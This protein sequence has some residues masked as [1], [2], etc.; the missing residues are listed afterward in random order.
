[1]GLICLQGGNE[2]APECRDMDA[3]LL[4]RAGGGTVVLVPLAGAPGRE[5]DTAGANGA[6]HFAALGAD[7]V[8]VAPD[9]RRDLAGALAAVND[10]RLLVLPGGSPRRLRDAIAGTPL[11]DAVHAAASD[12][13]R[14]VM[15]SS[16]GAMVLCRVTVLPRWRGTPETGEG[17]GV[18]G[19]FA[20]IPHYEGP[21]AAW[22]RA[23]RAAAPGTDLLGIPECSGVLLDG[24]AVTAV[25]AKPATLITGDGDREVLALDVEPER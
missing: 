1:M 12:P 19:D 2:F 16:A 8:R 13:G 5:Y 18:V 25:G 9:A 14:V 21:R 6:R 10:A 11:H 3:L 15:G 20:V 24:E 4:D 17:L 23:L 7:D 22:E